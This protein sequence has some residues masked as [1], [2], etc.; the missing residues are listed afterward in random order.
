MSSFTPTWPAHGWLLILALTSQVAGW[1]LIGYALPRLP[2]VETATI[3]LLQP[4]L[5]M[6]WAVLIFSESPSAI[7]WVG[8]ALVLVRRRL[9]R[10][11]PRPPH[12]RNRA[13]PTLTAVACV[14]EVRTAIYGLRFA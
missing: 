7:Q 5:T 9:R 11:R 6:I 14:P 1:L 2:A 12:P 4:V 8:A 10:H 13:G 3:I